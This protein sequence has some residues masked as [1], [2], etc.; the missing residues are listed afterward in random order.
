MLVARGEAW[1]LSLRAIDGPA[2]LAGLVVLISTLT[3]VRVWL[4]LAALDLPHDPP[5][6]ALVNRGGGDGDQRRGDL[7]LSCGRRRRVGATAV[8]RR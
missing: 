8:A 7:R 1:R 6:V 3:L 5:A 4:L 2:R